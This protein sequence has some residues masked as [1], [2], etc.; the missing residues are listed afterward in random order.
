MRD[1]INQRPPESTATRSFAAIIDFS[2]SFLNERKHNFERARKYYSNK[3]RLLIRKT[4][5]GGSPRSEFR[6]RYRLRK[7]YETASALFSLTS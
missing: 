1:Y 6:A 5:S 7:R 4:L 3:A 2:A